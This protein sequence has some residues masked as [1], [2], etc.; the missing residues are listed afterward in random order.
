MILIN[1][2]PANL[3]LL[4]RLL[5]TIFFLI[6]SF[7][8]IYGQKARGEAPPFRERLF[9]GGS[10]DLQFG[11]ITNINVSPIVGFWVLPRLAVAAGPEYK[12]YSEKYIGSTSIYGGRVYTQFVLIQDLNNIIPAGI[13]IGF[14]L[15]AEDELQSLQTKTPFW[16]NTQVT[17]SRF[18]VNT[19]LVGAGIS[20]PM[21]RRAALNIIALW[22][23]DDPYGIY[24][25]PEIRISFIF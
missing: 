5:L 13:H 21:G 1:I 14:F 12:Y 19:G 2:L 8:A 20:Q 3:K 15:H 24:S 23:L 6:T 11:T 10:F 16:N 18:S 17:T 22:A 4:S 7:S 9:F 25:N